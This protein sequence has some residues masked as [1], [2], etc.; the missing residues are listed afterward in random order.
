MKTTIEVRWF[1]DKA[2][3][4]VISWFSKFEKWPS[5]NNQ[6]LEFNYEWEQS[7]YYLKVGA[8][9]KMSFK[10]REGK[11]EIKQLNKNYGPKLLSNYAIGTI[12][13]WIKWSLEFKDVNASPQAIYIT[14]QEFQEIKK[15]RLLLK[16]EL[17]NAATLT[18]IDPSREPN[19]SFQ[20]E[21]SRLSFNVKEYFSS[22]WR[23]QR[24]RT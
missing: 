15:E 24:A 7:D 8:Y 17:P 23:W 18:R 16:F 13:R 20:V 11:S 14:P 6:R 5:E 2:P 3:K 1:F 10:I 19:N 12:E 9:S 4:N 21:L 22:A